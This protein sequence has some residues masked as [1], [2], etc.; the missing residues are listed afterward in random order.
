[1]EEPNANDEDEP[2]D[3][4]LD[5]PNDDYNL[6]DDSALA[7]ALAESLHDQQQPKASYQAHQL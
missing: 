2:D 6:D 1:M 4:G 3:W 7:K 5:T